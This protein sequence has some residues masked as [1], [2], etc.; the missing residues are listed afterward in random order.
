M[1]RTMRE[2][3]AF[4]PGHLTGFF[5]ICDQPEDPLQKGSRGSGVSITR[6]VH[7]KVQVEPSDRNS[8]TIIINDK[9]TRGALV[10]ENVLGKM[11]PRL[12]QPH[13][14]LVK[15]MFETPL[16]A[17][18]GSSGG[19]ALTLA[20]ALNEA[21]DLGLSL[22]EAAR[23]AHVTE[24]ECKTGLGTVFAAL[25][26]GFGALIKA[27][28]PGVGE[29]VKYD[30]SDELAVVYLHFGPMATKDA[31]SDPVIRRRINELGGRYVDQIKDDLRPDLFMELSRRFTEH[32]GLATHKIRKVFDATDREGYQCT[33]AMFGETAFA[34][35]EDEDAPGLVKV[36]KRA[37]PGFKVEV[38]GI[39]TVGARLL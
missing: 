14:I 39:D 21:L 15:H 36:L 19:G 37:A 26:G 27:G 10:S 9:V 38:T 5:Q 25:A 30:R 3:S 17:G 32:M 20:L 18:F 16:G 2:A 22:I 12:G 11:L 1:E 33:M 8:Y 28:G 34:L 6:G 4:A 29:A 7:T 35:I 24:I 31:L 13:K 23:V